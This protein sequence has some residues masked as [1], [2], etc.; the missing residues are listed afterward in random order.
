MAFRAIKIRPRIRFIIAPAATIIS[1]FHHFLLQNARSSSDDSSSPSMLTYP[2]I[3]RSL[4]AYFVSPFCFLKIAGPIPR[5]NSFTFTP[6][7]F[8]ETKCPSSCIAIIMPTNS[9]AISTG[10]TVLHTAEKSIARGKIFKRNQILSADGIDNCFSYYFIRIINIRRKSNV[11][12]GWLL[13]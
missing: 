8:A 9:I 13:G 10:H 11:F 6:K 3:G 4:S 2:P 1:F 5:A 7:R 12:R